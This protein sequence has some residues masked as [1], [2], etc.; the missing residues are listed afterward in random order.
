ME[1]ATQG[2]AWTLEDT[3][4]ITIG[5]KAALAEP[6]QIACMTAKLA[7]NDLSFEPSILFRPTPNPRLH[8]HWGISDSSLRA[9]YEGMHLA[10][11]KGTATGAK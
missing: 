1:K 11:T 2:V 8:S 4:N 3:F 10:T 6:L 7:S 5:Q 9:I